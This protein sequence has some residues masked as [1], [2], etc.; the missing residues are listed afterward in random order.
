VYTFSSASPPPSIPISFNT[1]SG[2]GF[3]PD[4]TFTVYTYT[5][6]V[7]T[8]IKIRFRFAGSFQVFGFFPSVVFAIYKNG[9]T[10]TNLY[11]S[12]TSVVATP[13]DLSG[14]ITF[15]ISP[16]DTI[17][18]RAIGS[19]NE[20]LTL[21]ISEWHATTTG[22]A[23]A[24][25]VPIGG[26]ININECI[27]KNIRQIDFFL[28]IVKLYNI[29]VYEDKF[30]EKLLYITPYTD[31]YSKNFSNAVDW[32][33]KLNRNKV[34]KVKPMS[35]L[36]A[37]IYKFKFKSDSDYYNDLYRKRYN[38]GYGDRVYDSEFEFTQ[39][40]NE[41]EIVFSATP[42]IGYT[43]EDKV[44]S[45]IFKQ[46]GNPPTITEENVDSNIRILQT[47]KVTGV[48]PWSIKNGSTVLNTLTRYG[49]AGHLDDP[50]IPTADINFG[51]PK[52][53]FFILTSG[54]L[55]NNQ[56][57]V[58]WSGYMRE[59]T[60]K[61]SKLVTGWFKLDTKDIL[62]LDFSKY[63]H[64]DGI[65]FR[66]NAISDFDMTNPN[67][68][69]VELFKVNSAAYTEAPGNTGPPEGCYLLWDNNEILDWS[70]SN[71]LLYGDCNT[72]PGDGGGTDPDPKYYL[73]WAF[74][75]IGGIAGIGSVNIYVDDVLTVTSNVNGETGSFEILEDQVI[76]VRVRYNSISPKP[77]RIFV[78]NDV[79]GVVIDNTSTANPYDQ[80]FIVQADKN[81]QVN[82]TINA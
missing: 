42:L 14:E 29:Y 38:E 13:F 25:P 52:E 43:G 64:V 35:E 44:Y 24:V 72:N 33:H 76:I 51:A 22:G 73:N 11:W 57:N 58:Y 77:K 81:Y 21:D 67:D 55:S 48:T 54:S 69:V 3:S 27:P 18:F 37:K 50:D 31:F 17:E 71:G 62:D 59:I 75:Q 28:A 15:S 74:S 6:T 39:Q 46:T 34:V 9:E 61:D 60:D 32:T 8:T 63:V 68:C 49:Y 80:T 78:S 5:G 82:A 23:I 10:G 4:G 19:P 20:I 2:G 53:L 45:T 65:A 7:T 16:S 40:N 12:G 36:N 56:F 26:A 66:L 79:D 70:D 1:L 47:K 30:D 41:F